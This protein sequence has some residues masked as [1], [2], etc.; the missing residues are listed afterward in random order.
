MAHH[1]WRKVSR[2]AG[3]GSLREHFES[4]DWRSQG[5]ERWIRGYAESDGK[6]GKKDLNV[7]MN[8]SGLLNT[9]NALVS[10][11]LSKAATRC[12]ICLRCWRCKNAG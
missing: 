3:Q 8:D 9:V 7:L 11:L 6:T 2:R 10:M 12:E 5:W 4:V 1:V